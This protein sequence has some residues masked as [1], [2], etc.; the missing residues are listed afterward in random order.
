M[1]S[2]APVFRVLVLCRDGRDST[3]VSLGSSEWDL[4]EERVGMVEPVINTGRERA[5]SEVRENLNMRTTPCSD[6]IF[7]KGKYSVV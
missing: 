7:M 6:R 1:L 2:L 5:I 4:R 3:T